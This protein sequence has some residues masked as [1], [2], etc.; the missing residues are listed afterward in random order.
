LPWAPLKEACQQAVQCKHFQT[1]NCFPRKNNTEWIY[2]YTKMRYYADS[3]VEM[4]KKCLL[5]SAF[6]HCNSESELRKLWHIWGNMEKWTY[7]CQAAD[8]T[9]EGLFIFRDQQLHHNLEC[10]TQ[11]YWEPR[12]F[13]C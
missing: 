11:V 5:Q 3:C 4:P 12:V 13:N 2:L 7:F 9:H 1:S 10:H 8:T 6:N